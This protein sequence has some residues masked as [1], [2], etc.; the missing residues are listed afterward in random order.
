M[1]TKKVSGAARGIPAE[2]RAGTRAATLAGHRLRPW[3]TI[4]PA[5]ATVLRPTLGALSEQTLAE[6]AQELPDLGSDLG[7]PY[8]EALRRGVE[9]ALEHF[10]GL[11]GGDEPALDDELRQI[12]EGFGAREDRHGRS[13]TI[14]L[15]AYRRGAQGAW[16]HFSAA[17]MAAGVP[18]EQLVR[19]A[20]AIFAYIEEL[21]STSALGF[22][23]A[24]AARAGQRDRI[25]QQLAET[26]LSGAASSH[27]PQLAELAAEAGWAL[28]ERAAAAVAPLART[29]EGPRPII[30]PPD[31]LVAVQDGEVCTIIPADSLRSHVRVLEALAPL[32]VGTVRPLEEI[33][34]SLM[35]ARA[36]QR[37]V[38]DGVIAS[39]P[40]VHAADHLP[41][42]LLHADPR[43]LADLTNRALAP[44]AALPDAKRATLTATLRS[45]LGHH[46]D[47]AACAADLS[48]HPQTVSYRM[49]RLE[50]L[51]GSALDDPRER[52]ALR[53]ALQALPR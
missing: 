9:G 36:V 52:L 2:G 27:A 30:L 19:L 1:V 37:V 3:S 33:H 41:E 35:H 47:R 15:A 8:G 32:A 26:L 45:W 25:R 39:A 16:R 18:T 31:V 51:F 17:A 46:G 4:D 5:I 29:P 24:H 14:L 34:L 6:I 21:S 53:M 42:L 23:Q 10:L 50:E 13:M 43:L 48:V 12:Y 20:E 49:S 22:A 11:L 44:L 40:V 38:A 28:P 7:G